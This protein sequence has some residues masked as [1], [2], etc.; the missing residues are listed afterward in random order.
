MRF[1]SLGNPW[2]SNH[3]KKQ[4]MLISRRPFLLKSGTFSISLG[5]NYITSTSRISLNMKV[6]CTWSN[7]WLHHNAISLLPIAPRTIDLP[8]KLDNGQ[9]SISLARDTRLCHFCSYT[10]VEN[11][12]HFML[13]CPLYN[14]IRDMYS[15]LFEKVVPKSLKPF[16][17]LDQ[18]VNIILYL[19]EATALHH[20]CKLAG[21]KPS[22]CIFSCSS[23]FGFLDFKINFISFLSTYQLDPI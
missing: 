20:S 22:W 2:Q 8:L 12:T 11:E 23:L 5:R 1:I 4:H 7:H 19:E 21:L 16:F 17:Q 14:P 3:I 9:L 18:Q 15:S 13:G 6:N 10:A